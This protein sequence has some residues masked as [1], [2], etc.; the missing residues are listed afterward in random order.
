MEWYVEGC[1]GKLYHPEGSLTSPGFPKKYKHDL[2]CVWEINVQYGY[3][4]ELTLHE[5]DLEYSL[6]CEYDYLEFSTDPSFNTT[7]SKLCLSQH[8]P[9]VISSGSRQLFVKFNSDDSNY[10]R[11]FNMTYRSILGDCGG[12]FSGT[13]GFI[14]TPNYPTRNYED[15]MNCEWNIKTDPSHSLTFQLTDFDL[16]ESL[17]CTKD[18]LEIYDPVFDTL[19]WMGCGNQLP[20][21][22]I[23][24]SN[25]NELNVRLIT[26]NSITAKGFAGNFSNNCGSRIAVNESGELVY[27]RSNEDLLCIWSIISADPTKKVMITFTYVNIFLETAD[28]CMST[29]E[30]F[31]GD[32]DSAPLKNRF[33]GVKTPPAIYSNGNAL[34][35]K[36][37]ATSLSYIGEFDIYYSVLDNGKI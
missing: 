18:R 29:V 12:T 9:T 11:G 7:I 13:K 24:K 1:G 21:K 5:L 30:V 28:G 36:L 14:S 25:R 17:I 31:D 32:S 8:T 37:N 23:F 19:L 3:N 20:N 26:D 34:T 2:T 22:T 33:C 10:G 4:I 35:V 15:K 27:R 16:E 6:T